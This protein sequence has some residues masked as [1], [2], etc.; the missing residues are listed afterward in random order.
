MDM[1]VQNDVNITRPDGAQTGTGAV[2]QDAERVILSAELQRRKLKEKT[3]GELI[4]IVN[5]ICMDLDI[6]YFAVGDLLSFC[7]AGSDTDPERRNYMMVMMREDYDLFMAAA[8]G[9]QEELQIQVL[10]MYGDDGSVE[11]IHSSVT[12]FREERLEGQYANIELSLQIDPYEI[13]PENE[14]TRKRFI[15]T[16]T[17]NS[18]RMIADSMACINGRIDRKALQKGMHAVYRDTFRR[19]KET[20]RRQIHHFADTGRPVLAGGIEHAVFRPHRMDQI[21][22]IGQRAFLDTFLMIPAKTQDF[23]DSIA[24]KPEEDEKKYRARV[25]ALEL[26]DRLCEKNSLSYTVMGSLSSDVSHYGTCRDEMRLGRWQL[27]LLRPDYEKA[28]A[29]LRRGEAEPGLTFTEAYQGN[30]QVHMDYAGFIPSSWERSDPWVRTYPIEL[31]PLDEASDDYDAYHAFVSSSIRFYRRHR[32]M[33]RGETCQGHDPWQNESDTWEMFDRMHLERAEMARK[34]AKEGLRDGKGE[35]RRVFTIYQNRPRSYQRCDLFPLERR[36][37][38]GIR[39]WGPARALLWHERKDDLFSEEIAAERTKLIKIVDRIC[40]A[41][42]IEYFAIANLL[43]GAA[44]YH[45]YVPGSDD[46]NYD[47]GM[48]RKDYERFLAYMRSHAQEHGLQLNEFRDNRRRYPLLTKTISWPDGEYSN[49]IIRFLPFD[50]VPED[51]YLYQGFIEDM[52]RENKDLKALLQSHTYTGPVNHT[53]LRNPVTRAL[54]RQA[55][56]GKPD[57]E[58]LAE[59]V[60]KAEY[61]AV[62]DPLEMAERIDRKAQ[63]FNDDSRTDTYARVAM[64]RSKK[65]PGSELFPLKRIPFRDM[66]LSC[67]GDYSAWQPMLNREL[68]RQVSCIQKADL[69]LLEE[70]DRVCRELGVGYFVCGGTMLGYMRHKGFIPWDDDVDVAM[71]RRD[72]DRFLQ[73]AGPL[74]KER[75]FL[76]TRET[77]PHIPYLFSKVRLDDTEYITEYNEDRDFH[78]GI[79]LDIFPFDFLPDRPENCQEYVQEVI[80]L[81]KVHNGVANHQYAY[82]QD[83]LAPRNA[84]EKKYISRQKAQLDHY[85]KQDLRK[86]QKAYLDAATRYNSQAEELGLTVVASFL[87]DFTYIDL[88]DLLPY[89]R[90]MFAGVEVYVPKRPDVFLTMQYGDFMELPPKHQQVAHRLVRWSTWTDSWDD[91]EA[92]EEKE[93][94]CGEVCEGKDS[95]SEGKEHACGEV[96]EEKD[97]ADGR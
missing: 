11:R 95:A 16:L 56:A 21:F 13:L 81:S 53:L 87:P 79:C 9:A 7:L 62:R 86:T 3:L 91:G 75:F 96:C 42:K 17:V 12:I 61:I 69:V 41:E 88:G 18:R 44:I 35:T 63:M 22:P 26:F 89:Q 50:K 25:A 32:K 59:S 43:V 51:F 65:I 5:D 67:P 38:D 48:L 34:A 4:R 68:E 82:P 30:P 28:V 54:A 39:V 70:F 73:N 74:L 49:V 93:P 37:L 6:S 33:I 85:W 10:P 15:R 2:N 29:L 52:N 31:Y 8:Q 1:T 71:L 76:Q 92:G 84:Q 66:M 40:A 97:S 57:L 23:I 77:D 78:K 64:E 60:R 20:Y 83:T 46:R 58:A 72:Y 80:A 90:G 27:G 14:K 24:Q 19:M 55:K 45:D 36:T 47:L 94:A